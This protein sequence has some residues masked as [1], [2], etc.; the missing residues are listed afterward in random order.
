M[1]CNLQPVGH[2]HVVV[3]SRRIVRNSCPHVD[4][5]CAKKMCYAVSICHVYLRFLVLVQV[6]YDERLYMMKIDDE[7]L[8]VNHN[9]F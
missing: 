7:D 1:H 9:T 5:T 2:L 6:G 3:L 8:L 4:G